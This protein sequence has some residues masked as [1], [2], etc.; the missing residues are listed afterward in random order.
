MGMQNSIVPNIGRVFCFPKVA[1]SWKDTT[2]GVFD[3]WL[4]Q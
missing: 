3:L 1:S 4:S 2:A